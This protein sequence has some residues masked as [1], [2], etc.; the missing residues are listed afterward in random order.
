M[1]RV[2]ALRRQ[3]IGTLMLLALVFHACLTPSMALGHA[4]LERSIPAAGA[5]LPVAPVQVDIWFTE[6][7]ASGLSTIQVTDV[8]R[9]RVDLADST[10]DSS[11]GHHLVVSL[12][13]L[14][15]GLYTVIWANLSADDGHP[16]KG[17][18]AFSLL[19]PTATPQSAVVA[20]GSSPDV[21]PTPV[22][23]QTSLPVLPQQSQDAEQLLSP[24]TDR[25]TGVIDILAGW[26]LFLALALAGGGAAFAF[27]CLLPALR[28]AEAAVLRWNQMLQWR[29]FVAV[30]I[31][32]IV[33]TAAACA[34]LLAKAEIATSLPPGDLMSGVVLG[35]LLAPWSGRVWLVR[36]ATMLGLALVA[37]GGVLS[38][39]GTTAPSSVA[40]QRWILGAITLCSAL[41]VILTSLESHI[42]A[43]HTARSLPFGTPALAVHL[44]AVGIW[45]GGLGYAMLLLPMWR[46]ADDTVR[47]VVAVGAIARFSPFALVSVIAIALSGV[48][49]AAVLV[50]APEDLLTSAY[51][52]ALDA[53]TALFLVLIAFG[54][55][56]RRTLAPLARRAASSSGVATEGIPSQRAPEP[57]TARH[58]DHAVHD[59][60]DHPYWVAPALSGRGRPHPAAGSPLRAYAEATAGE[61]PETGDHADA[62]RPCDLIRSSGASLLRTMRR[63]CGVAAAVLLAASVMLE[64]GPPGVALSRGA[65]QLES[66]VPLRELGVPSAPPPTYTP[67]AVASATPAVFATSAMIGDLSIAMTVQP[68][69]A[70]S[71][72]DFHIALATASQQLVTGALVKLW[73]TAK[74]EDLGT[75]TFTTKSTEPGIYRVSAPV[76]AAPGTWQVQVVVRQDTVPD[77]E[78]TF[79]VPVAVPAIVAPASPTV[80]PALPTVVGTPIPVVLRATLSFQPDPPITG[81]ADAVIRLVDRRGKP[82]AGALLHAIWIMPQHAHLE[83]T[84]V[85]ETPAGSGVYTARVPFTMAG[86]WQATVQANLSDGQSVPLQFAFNV[87]DRGL[88][89]RGSL[90]LTD[91]P[92]A[93]ASPAV[94]TVPAPSVGGSEAPSSTSGPPAAD[95]ALASASPGPSAAVPH[96][97]DTPSGKQSVPS[98]TVAGNGLAQERRLDTLVTSFQIQ[99]RILQPTDI[100]VRLTGSD[101][102]LIDDARR[103]DVQFAMEGMSHG[104]LGAMASRTSRGIYRAHGMLLVMEGPW[105]MALRVER[106]DGTIESGLFRFQVPFDRPSGAVSAFAS[107]PTDPIQIVDVAVYPG[108]TSPDTISV[109]AGHAVRLEV[110][111]VDRPACPPAVRVDDGDAHTDLTSEGL[112]EL[113]FVPAHTTQLKLSCTSSGL[114][115]R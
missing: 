53:K 27:C 41:A 15:P 100:T 14:P 90:P 18:F 112:G 25:A 71:T 88:F 107:R 42:A 114:L 19:A 102:L 46:H 2:S 84:T 92:V 64:V 39:Y 34:S 24:A 72:S 105:W 21:Q 60:A 79:T 57:T 91:T 95:R 89:G 26:L 36:E 82:V 77:R 23:L 12:S 67:G 29:F 55:L 93:S 78:I 28:G 8:N 68:A 104:A 106:A 17:G 111:Y 65:V 81:G 61:R 6:K 40:R 4:Q 7:V 16:D 87:R 99:P 20:V 45:V 11:D 62:R 37:L 66:V 109:R 13:S 101:G 108:E 96:A 22:T 58:A 59:R 5:V 9:K 75:Q 49:I 54:A 103:V 56:N 86:A 63:E 74:D 1:H 31:Y 51:G 50:P 69:L 30:T 113:S 3:F 98:P 44:L 110:I 38:K 85:T 10:V 70:G 73:I 48:Y 83:Q 52:Q 47:R 80:P 32:A 115:L 97:S 33:A 43:G 76:F 94:A 35:A